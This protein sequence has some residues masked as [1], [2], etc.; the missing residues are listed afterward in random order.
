MAAQGER[1]GSPPE[2]QGC[3]DDDETKMQLLCATRE[4]FQAWEPDHIASKDLLDKLVNR[5]DE[6][7]AALWEKD[8]EAGNTKGPGARLAKFLKPFG[9]ISKTIREPDGSTPKGYAVASFGEAFARYLPPSS[10]SP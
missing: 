9:I 6:P 8:I 1:R 5:E 3:T 7:W 10:P 2:S 4:I